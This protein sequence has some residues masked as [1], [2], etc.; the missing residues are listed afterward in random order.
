[1]CLGVFL[2]GFMLPG[3]LCFLDLVD[4]FISHVREDFSYYLCY[5]LRSFLSFFSSG[6]PMVQTFAYL[7]LSQRSLG[8]SSFF[9]CLFVCFILFSVFFSEAMISTIQ[10]YRSFIHSSASVILLLVSSSVLLFISVC[11]LVLVGFSKQ[12]FH[13]L[14]CLLKILDHLHYHYSEFIFWKVEYPSFI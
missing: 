9:V 3:T 7:M 10:S 1:M 6:T 12:F 4:Y 8:L 5:F 14:H 2:L 13:L 11:S